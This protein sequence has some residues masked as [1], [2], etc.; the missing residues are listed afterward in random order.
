MI[1]RIA[2]I[3]A[4]GLLLGAAMTPAMAAD[5]GGGCCADLEERVAELEA[6][7]ARKGNRVVTLQ[8]YG[9]VAKGLLI[10][11]NGDNSD[12]YVV[13]NDAITSILGFKGKAALK[14]GWTA[15]FKVE[16]A[17]QDASS[18]GISD[19]VDPDGDGPLARRVGD[20]PADNISIRESYVYIESER[21]GRVS[22]G[23][24]L[25]AAD[26]IAGISIANTLYGNNPDHSGGLQIGGFNP[27]NSTP[28]TFV[29]NFGT[30]RNDAIRYDSP[31]IYGFIAS[32]T[33]GDDD[34]WDV[35]LRFAKEW[36]SFKI[37]AG[38][39]YASFDTDINSGVA[40][41]LGVGADVLSGSIS[42]LHVPTGL[43]ANFGAGTKERKSDDA[44]DGNDGDFW[45]VQGGIERKWL[46][47]GA[48][49]LHAE[50]GLANDIGTINDPTYLSSEAT[51]WG[52]GVVQ[53]FDSA[54][55]D[56]Y[57]QATFW[58]FEGERIGADP[59]F[60]DMSTLM[61]GA[62]IDF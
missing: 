40:Q 42:V 48:T 8:I 24:Q 29:S 45:F 55:L 36:N 14:P 28:G 25:L 18:N 19:G 15:G 17:V 47:Y 26:G 31:S 58:S 21:L 13:D 39:G 41:Q 23:Q 56:L 35:T 38:I 5:L 62:K 52:F 3:A 1:S 30:G 12:A 50:Y 43:F 49:T 53:H 57:A 22:I 60:E 2:L 32:A 10:W 61:V 20:D 44:A 33:W 37:A 9:T 59:D 7:T 16:L 27:A 6:T 4:A 34:Y 51:R 11:D 46:S 54:A